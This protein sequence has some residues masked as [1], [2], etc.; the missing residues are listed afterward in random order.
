MKGNVIVG[1]S[2]GPPLSI[3]VWQAFIKRLLHAVQEKYTEC[4]TESKDC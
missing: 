4:V 1:Q 3:P 2:G